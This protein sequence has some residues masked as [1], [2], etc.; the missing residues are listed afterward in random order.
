MR[1]ED[2]FNR[3]MLEE[4]ILPSSGFSA[5]VMD[6]VRR[7]AATPAPIAFPWKRALPGIVVAAA[8]LVTILVICIVKLFEPSSSAT[9]QPVSAWQILLQVH[10]QWVLLGVVVVLAMWK[11]P[12]FLGLRSD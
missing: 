6:A 1:N 3:I 7:E 5:S 8:T 10:T 4:E 2:E 12:S 9:G 11:M